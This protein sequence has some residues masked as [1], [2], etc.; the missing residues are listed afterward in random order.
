MGF[1]VKPDKGACRALFRMAAP[2]T[3]LGTLLRP[4][5]AVFDRPD[6]RA[7]PSDFPADAGGASAQSLCDGAHAFSPLKADGNLLPFREGEMGIAF[8]LVCDTL[9]HNG[10]APS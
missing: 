10:I 8:S 1:R 5:S 9:D 3:L 4:V 2:G 7:V 6:G